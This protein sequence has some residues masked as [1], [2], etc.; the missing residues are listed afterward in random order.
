MGGRGRIGRNTLAHANEVRDGRIYAN[1]A[2]VLIGM[3]REL[4]RDES[5]AVDL[6]AA[7]HVLDST[8]ID[9]CLSLFP[10]GAFRHRRSSFKIRTLLDLRGIIPTHVYL[11]GG[12][13]HDVNFLDQLRL[14]AGAFYWDQT[15]P[16]HQDL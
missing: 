14:E 3:A 11:S 6:S 4:Y 10:W 8:S 15:T 7:V 16:A 5:F 13:L 1:F 2:H 9:W 12:H